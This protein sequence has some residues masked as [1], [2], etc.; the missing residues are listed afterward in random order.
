[1]LTV[2]ITSKGQATIPKRSETNVVFGQEKVSP[3]KKTM[4]F[5]L[6]LKWQPNIT[7]DYLGPE[8]N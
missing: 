2:K 5:V 6:L 7:G 1:M 4:A 3:L 8:R